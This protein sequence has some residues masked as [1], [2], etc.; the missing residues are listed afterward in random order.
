MIARVS[1]LIM[2]KDRRV[3]G[4]GDVRHDGSLMSKNCM[5]S[6]LGQKG[7]QSKPPSFSGHGILIIGS[8]ADLMVIIAIITIAN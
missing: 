2:L 7:V 4:V 6:Q 1:V 8:R 3:I 5:P